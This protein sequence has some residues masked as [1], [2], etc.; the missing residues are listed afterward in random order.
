MTRE[1]EFWTSGH[2]YEDLAREYEQH[3][4]ITHPPSV[5]SNGIGHR[6]IHHDGWCASKVTY[7]EYRGPSV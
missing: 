3:I 7:Y 2:R 4:E 1:S 6:F 5:T